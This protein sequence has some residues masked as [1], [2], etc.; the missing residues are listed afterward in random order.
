[1][2]L[3]ASCMLYSLELVVDEVPEVGDVLL[4]VVE[5]DEVEVEAVL[6]VLV[7]VML[8]D[9]DGVELLVR[10][11]VFPA[12]LSCSTC[13]R[14]WIPSASSFLSTAGTTPA[15]GYLRGHV[16]RTFFAFRLEMKVRC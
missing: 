5:E 6:V 9:D 1:M 3:K 8:E 11:A 13:S 10:H 15:S 2:R 14:R 7:D 16:R 4:G 12:S